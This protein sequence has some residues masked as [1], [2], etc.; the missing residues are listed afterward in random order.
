[1]RFAKC[2]GKSHVFE[3]KSNDSGILDN[4]VLNHIVDMTKQHNTNAETK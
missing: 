2:F 4:A 1:M 3:E